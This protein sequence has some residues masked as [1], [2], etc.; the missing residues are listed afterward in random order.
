MKK[1][2]LIYFILISQGIT[3]DGLILRYDCDIEVE[4][5]ITC[6][7]E[8]MKAF[9]D[10]S[11]FIK[12]GQ[13]VNDV[14]IKQERFFSPEINVEIK[15]P[16]NP[17]VEQTVLK[18]QKRDKY[19]IKRVDFTLLIPENYN[20]YIRFYKNINVLE[21]NMDE[22]GKPQAKITVIT[23]VFYSKFKSKS[24]K[25]VLLS[26]P[27]TVRMQLLLNF[28][29]EEAIEQIKR[30]LRERGEDDML[31][32]TKKELKERSKSKT[33]NQ[34]ELYRQA[35]KNNEKVKEQNREKDRMMEKEQVKK[36]KQEAKREQEKVK[37][38]RKKEE[39]EEKKKK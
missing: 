30:R 22:K 28:D 13:I 3:E 35:V 14:L 32:L 20:K 26:P 16:S 6:F 36:E 24:H 33:M 8:S 27:N 17:F 31:S 10:K 11:S 9:E 2:I 21:I 5:E 29:N 37:K 4:S 34:E 7:K 1:I 25:N 12:I 15:K 18:Y 23:E 19:I 38:E 39:K